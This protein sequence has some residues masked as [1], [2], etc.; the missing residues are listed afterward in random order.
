MLIK[1]SV[2][3]K[4]VK[5]IVKFYRFLQDSGYTL[6]S[7]PSGKITITYYKEKYEP[8]WLTKLV[9]EKDIERA[10]NLP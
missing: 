6:S 3:S 7:D 9:L 4:K 2:D 8:T 1:K 10:A 5:N